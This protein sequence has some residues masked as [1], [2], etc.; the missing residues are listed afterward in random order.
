MV[1]LS[2]VLIFANG[3]FA[4]EDSPRLGAS[5]GVLSFII[6]LGL[7]CYVYMALAV[8]TIARKTDTP[9]DWLAW[10]PLANLFLLLRISRKPLWWFVRL[11]IPFVNIVIL[12]LM[13]IGVAEA[14]GKP[15]WWGLLMLVPV[16]SLIVPGYL[17]WSD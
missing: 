17:A 13:W 4:Q 8:Q 14:R 7:V 2:C 1:M 15:N 5:A 3:A 9:N 6:I 12:I 16:V 10:I 11:L